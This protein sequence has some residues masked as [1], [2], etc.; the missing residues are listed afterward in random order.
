[1]FIRAVNL[2]AY[3]RMTDRAQVHTNL[4]SA[5]RVRNC[6]NQTEL[7]RLK[8]IL[9]RRALATASRLWSRATTRSNESSLNVKFSLRLCATRVDHSFQPDH[10]LLMFALSIQRRIDEVALPFGP[11]PDDREIFFLHPLPLHQQ[12]EPACGRR[13]F[14]NEHQTAGLAVEPIHDGNLTAA[15]NLECE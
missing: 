7:V 2:V 15:G 10:R 14:R 12:P 11:S 8:H 1:V 5:S 13:C 6:A 4:M 9:D 3:N